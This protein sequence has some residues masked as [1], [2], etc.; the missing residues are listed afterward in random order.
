MEANKKISFGFT[1]LSKKPTVVRAQPL[2]ENKVELIECLEGHSIKIKDAV[3]VVDEP[4]VIPV[5]GKNKTLSD[6]IKEAQAKQ[7]ESYTEVKKEDDRPDSELT[8]KEQAARALIN[9][10][11][12]RLENNV[13]S[14]SKV[15]ILP[16]KE[17]KL[18]IEGEEEPT[19]EDYENVPISDYG[20]AMLRGMGWKEGMGIGKTASKAA[21]AVTPELRPKGLGLGATRV[22]KTEEPAR[23]KEGNAL[24]L[25]KGCYA[26]FTMGSRKGD[27]CEVLGL[28]DE[29]GRVI[30]RT[31][32]KGDTLTVN[33]FL[34]VPVTKEEYS[35]GAKVINNAKYEEYKKISDKRLEAYR[36]A[37]S[38]TSSKSKSNTKTSAQSGK[39]HRDGKYASNDDRLS[40][41]DEIESKGSRSEKS[42]NNGKY[43]KNRSRYRDKELSD[44]DSDNRHEESKSRYKNNSDS[45]SKNR[46]RTKDKKKKK[47]R[48]RDRSRSRK[49]KGKNDKKSKSKHRDRSRS[50]RER[51]R[52]KGERSKA[53]KSGSRR[54]H[55]SGSSSSS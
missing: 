15:T 28:D 27:Y 38:S 53:H 22:I 2:E 48:H 55:K 37:K 24:I 32:L 35:Q 17:D 21:V 40:S 4:L 23:D 54:R 29:A 3:E 30:V 50:P 7:K 45:D 11:K 51:S 49:E 12:N 34:I 25:K 31:S 36:E 41:G 44:S 46:E 1:K 9:E 13:T 14:S 52:K 5:K 33:E 39:Q 42:K 8:L 43:E 6:R 18:V 10:A 47:D 19:Q 20:M 16:V 26:K